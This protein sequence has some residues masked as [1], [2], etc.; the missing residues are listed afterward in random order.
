MRWVVWELLAQPKVHDAGRRHITEVLGIP[1]HIQFVCV[2]EWSKENR[3]GVREKVRAHTFK[4]TS[5]Q[6]SWKK[7]SSRP[8][9]LLILIPW[10]CLCVK[11]NN[12]G[13]F[14]RQEARQNN[15]QLLSSVNNRKKNNNCTFSVIKRK[16][17]KNAKNYNFTLTQ[18]GEERK[19]LL[20]CH[21]C[22]SKEKHKNIKREKLFHTCSVDTI[23]V[24]K[25]KKD[26][27]E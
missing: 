24:E 20:G 10:L 22:I 26:E 27:E 9:Y 5:L 21:C 8:S 3:K 13:Q 1:N 23:I 4:S 12:Q 14:H 6:P 25:A 19:K 17:E 18:M 11:W 7:E 2:K 15:A 16:W